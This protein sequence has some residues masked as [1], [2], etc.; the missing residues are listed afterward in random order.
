MLTQKI[1]EP[2]TS[3]YNSTIIL[4]PKKST[5]VSDNLGRAKYFSTLDLY[6]GFWQVPLEEQSRNLT[7]FSTAEGS[8]RFNVLPFGLNVAPNSFARMMSIAFSGLDPAT[9]FLYLDDI[10]VVGASVEHHLKNLESV[11]YL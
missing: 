2:S 7:S 9:A 5:N 10:I 4:V 3:S 8:F 6:S 1:I 11:Q